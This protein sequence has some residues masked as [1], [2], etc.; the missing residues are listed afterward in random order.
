MMMMTRHL[1]AYLSVRWQQKQQQQQL[2]HKMQKMQHHLSLSAS[3]LYVVTPYQCT[4]IAAVPHIA[5]P[6]ASDSDTTETSPAN[7]SAGSNAPLATSTVSP[8][9]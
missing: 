8:S 5:A 2:I 3:S 9:P 7:G 1:Q 6:V 4:N